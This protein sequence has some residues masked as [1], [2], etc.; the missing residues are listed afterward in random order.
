MKR[1]LLG[2]PMV[3]G[4]LCLVLLGA[5]LSRPQPLLF[6]MLLFM[7]TGCAA[8]LL[9]PWLSLWGTTAQ[10]KVDGESIEGLPPTLQ[11]LIANRAWWPVFMVSAET[12]WRWGPRD[13]VLHHDIAALS[14]GETLDLGQE[15][16]FPCRGLYELV[17]IRLS[18]GFPLGLFEPAVRRRQ[19]DTRHLV[20][21]RSIDVELP[22]LAHDAEDPDSEQV[23]HRH[24]H[25]TELGLLRPYQPGDPVRR[26]H[27]RASARTGELIIQ[28]LHQSGSPTLRVVSE[29]PDREQIGIA[30]APAEQAIRVAAGLCRQAAAA[31]LR[32]KM[33]L[34]PGAALTD[35]DEFC[36][37]LAAAPAGSMPLAPTI[38]AA[39]HDMLDGESLAIVVG[40]AWQADD[41]LRLLDV[42]GLEPARLIIFVALPAHTGAEEADAHPLV[43]G[44]RRAGI[45]SRASF[46]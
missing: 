10:A 32:L 7:T 30:D 38:A 23:N 29:V 18:S 12:R 42:P 3:M 35:A 39:A 40:T 5:T 45:D 43:A 4:L 33:Q 17:E 13:L 16:R 31:R 15:V 44:L 24:G 22:Q 6:F 19:R 34:G 28:Q 37:A 36:R 11:L 2:K 1:V 21:P 26:A 25:S 20:L 46:A 8:A 41:V 14:R 27:W 9:L